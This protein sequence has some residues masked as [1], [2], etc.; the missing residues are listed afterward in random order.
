MLIQIINKIKYNQKVF[1]QKFFRIL[2]LLKTKIK[3]EKIMEEIA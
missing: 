3:K 2:K 1:L